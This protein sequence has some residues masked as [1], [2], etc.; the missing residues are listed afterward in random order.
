MSSD[1]VEAESGQDE[2]DSHAVAIIT[3]SLFGSSR[4]RWLVLDVGIGRKFLVR[5]PASLDVV[6]MHSHPT[7]KVSRL[8]PNT[9]PNNMYPEDPQTGTLTGGS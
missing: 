9:H 7:P 4:V 8:L 5:L 1:G 3:R 6:A 2:S